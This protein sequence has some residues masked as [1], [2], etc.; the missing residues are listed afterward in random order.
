MLSPA[1]A[2]RTTDT[3]QPWGTIV[4]TGYDPNTSAPM[5][6][7]N[8]LLG[9]N[10]G[11]TRTSALNQA[12][13]AVTNKA[14]WALQTPSVWSSDSLAALNTA[15][16]DAQAA[17]SSTNQTVVD[18]AT[19]EL[20]TALRGLRRIGPYP[21]GGGPY[22]DPY[23]LPDVAYL[24]DPFTFL[25]GTRVKSLADWSRRR[26]EIKSLAQYYEYGWMPPTPASLTAT[27]TGTTTRTIGLTINDNGHTYTNANAV[28]LT[29]PS[30]TTVNGKTAPWP[31]IVS[32]DLAATPGTPSSVYTAAGYAV[33]DIGYTAWA[34]DSGT[35]GTTALQTLY[36]YDRSTGHDY[37]SLMG[38]AYGASRALDA[39]QYLIANDANY[40][41]VNGLGQTVPLIDMNKASVL[42]FSR[43]GKSSLFAGMIDTRF[44][45]T[46]AGGSGDGGAAPYR[47]AADGDYPFRPKNTFG[48]IYW[49][50]STSTGAGGEAM[51][52]HIR[53]NT[54]NTNDMSR[55][56]LNDRPQSDEPGP[57]TYQPRMYKQYTWGYGT[58]LPYDH[59]LVISAIA[60]RAIY[61]N[62][63]NDDYADES[64]G[65]NVGWEGAQA[66]YK[67]LGLTPW[68]AVDTYMGGGGHSMKT[69]QTNNFVRFLDY[70]LYG[71]PLPTTPPPGDATNTP[72]NV[73]LYTDPYLTGAVDHTST[74]DQYYGGL[75]TMMPWLPI[76]PHANLLTA[77]TLSAG[78]I[79]PAISPD[80]T[81]YTA[82]V[83]DNV[84]SITITPT[85]EDSRATVKVNGAVIPSG[86]P[87][88]S[89]PLVSGVN[90][91][92]ID[93]TS[94]DGN[95]RVYNLSVSQLTIKLITTAT[96][97]K[98]ADNSYNATVTL[99][100]NGSDT[101][102]S[103]TIS[104]ATLGS[105][106]GSPLPATLGDIPAGGSATTTIH[107]PASAGLSK[108]TVAE[109]YSGTYTGGSFGSS[110]RAT[111]P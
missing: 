63:T 37:G 26:D 73:Q 66:V 77:I 101:A 52:D 104:A 49:W 99:T 62:N 60:P 102:H 90:P 25:D 23:D 35:V 65:D 45:V 5:Q 6:L 42:G 12:L 103:V 64:E 24:P 59:H 20:D 2:N 9:V 87:S 44:K 78:S 85:A 48:H 57:R 75:S 14:T 108:A 19:A 17:M 70:V 58:R 97:T 36:P 80:I 13:P 50:N 54:W 109:K 106:S 29:L 16:S 41:V 72:T 28:K 110:I 3:S 81:S 76:V 30:G 47:Y 93:V 22:P 39:A 34:T 107:F 94:I 10:I 33:L 88:Q 11:A 86:Q 31:V 21:Y 100:N 7:D 111:L 8:F 74:Y 51:G 96:L 40:T 46:S 98:L 89:I 95:T 84:P 71:I 32:I 53:H 83:A 1:T 61:I 56:F 15:F 55:S 67:Y 105:P 92:E 27:S 79:S 82:S 68:L 4:L 91:V 18:N 38:W 69:S 43:A